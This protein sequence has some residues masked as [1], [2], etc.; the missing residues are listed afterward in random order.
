[1]AEATSSRTQD[2][3]AEELEFQRA[4]ASMS[5]DLEQYVH[6]CQSRAEYKEVT[7][8]VDC[9]ELLDHCITKLAYVKTTKKPVNLKDLAVDLC[10]IRSY[11]VKWM[12]VFD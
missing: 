6:D 4:V 8:S 11:M 1:M 7:N 2:Q 3:A 12:E 9:V 5:H 10:V